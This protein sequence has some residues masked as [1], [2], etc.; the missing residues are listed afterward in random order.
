MG[1]FFM[2]LDMSPL[3]RGKTLRHGS[4]FLKY[5]KLLMFAIHFV[6]QKWPLEKGIGFEARAAHPCPNQ[7][8]VPPGR[9]YYVAVTNAYASACLVQHFSLY[10]SSLK[11]YLDI[12]LR[13]WFLS[14][15]LC[16]FSSLRYIFVCFRRWCLL[17]GFSVDRC[18][19][20]L[21]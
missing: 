10:K 3:F 1:R 5:S 15:V 18:L 20:C 12:I 16:N 4:F 17:Q 7:I 9:Y 14:S 21:T 8:R 19:V 11:R 13:F 6:L 2:S